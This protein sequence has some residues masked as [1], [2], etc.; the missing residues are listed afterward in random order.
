MEEW[1]ARSSY[2]SGKRIRVTNEGV[3]LEGITRGLES[4]GAL[5][6]ET[7]TGEIKIVRAGDVS[8]TRAI[9]EN[10]L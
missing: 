5:R 4:D 6:I 2:A 3:I 9:E 8:L 1:S 7:D 10:S